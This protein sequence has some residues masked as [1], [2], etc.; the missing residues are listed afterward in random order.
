MAAALLDQHA[1]GRVRVRS[2]GTAPADE[3]NPAVVAAM[4]EVG[5][6]VSRAVPTRLADEMARVA[7]VVVTMGCGDS[8]PV[9]PGVRRL[10]WELTDPAGRPVEEV[11]AIRDEIDQLVRGLLAELVGPGP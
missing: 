11:R 9:Y 4:A 8:C 3:V 1:G 6:D 2:A 10:D 7:D 5:I